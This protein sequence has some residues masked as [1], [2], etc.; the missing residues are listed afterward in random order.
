MKVKNLHSTPRY[1]QSNSQVESSNKTLLMALKKRLQLAKGKWV[2]ELPRV[3]WA[4]RTSN[5]KPTRMS[6]FALTYKMESIIP[7]EIGIPTLR[8]EIPEEANAEAVTIDLDMT[9]KLREA[10]AMRIAS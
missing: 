10:A 3:L 5:R 7:T 9:D 8:T 4:Y 1:P 2:N 6:S